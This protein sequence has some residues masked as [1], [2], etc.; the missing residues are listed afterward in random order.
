M[1]A[2]AP[3]RPGGEG[4]RLQGI[5]AF[6]QDSE[7]ETMLRRVAGQLALPNFD[8]RRGGV[9]VAVK[10]LKAERSPA[11]LFIDVTGIDRVLDAVQA[12]SDVCEP[13]LQV[14]VIGATNDVGLYRAL[15]R[16]GV[17]DYLF[18]PMTA[19]LLEAVIWRL[20]S[21]TEREG[22]GRL[23][24]LVAVSGARGGAGASSIA[25][26]VASYLA[27][28]ASR[29]VCLLDLDVTTGAQAMLLGT[30]PN[31]GLAEALEVPGRVDDLF[32]E[33]ATIS[34]SPRLDLLA[35]EMPAGRVPVI[36][37]EAA[38]ALLGRLQRNYHYVVMDIPI[39]VRE[40]CAPLLAAVHAQLLVTE[41]TLLG[42]RDAGTR[43]NVGG[44]QR[45]VL[46]HNKAGRPGDLS[47]EDFATGLRRQPDA[48]IPFLP[49]V[50]GSAINLGRPAWQDEPRAE[51]AI[52]ILARELS[53]QP[54][55][56]EPIPAWKRLIGL[57][58]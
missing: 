13:Q 8:V 53:G 4:S 49:R 30:R 57:A 48:T 52:A 23:G 12:L 34:V 35:S 19:E 27:D 28:K 58:P 3:I 42:A 2:M 29:R 24:K 46:V 38:E 17:A 47:A 10:D 31:A 41:A 9:D 16:M 15:I 50:F 54:V 36:T 33:R 22:Q 45:I 26:N 39:A 21:G 32:L 37:S 25:A 5:L 51:T 18:K 6:V 7:S 14:V 1:N 44:G 11:L 40:L 56:T 20:M 55:R 43:L